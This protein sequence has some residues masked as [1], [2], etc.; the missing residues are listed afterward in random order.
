MFS[1]VYGLIGLFSKAGWQIEQK[2]HDT[3]SRN[4]SIQYGRD[5][6]LDKN[7]Y[8]RLV[9]NNQKVITHINGCGETLRVDF[10]CYVVSVV[11]KKDEKYYYNT[12]TKCVNKYNDS[13]FI[14]YIDFNDNLNKNSEFVRDNITGK[15]LTPRAIKIDKDSKK[16]Y[17]GRIHHFYMDVVTLKLVRETDGE[18]EL[19][20]KGYEKSLSKEYIDN[21]I[22][23]YNDNLDKEYKPYEKRVYLL[24]DLQRETIDKMIWNQNKE[25][26]CR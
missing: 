24:G 9:K 1:I 23:E 19:R 14:N 2:I 20:N 8:E 11:N 12:V 6:Y 16:H 26:E 7:G 15:I 21:F 22:I 25:G 13:L 18:I 5:I 4:K 3:Q 10:C 17:H